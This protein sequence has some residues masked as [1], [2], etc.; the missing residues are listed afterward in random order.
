MID[1]IIDHTND[2]FVKFLNESKSALFT[3]ITNNSCPDS[4][5]T[6]PFVNDN[7]IVYVF[8]LCDSNKIYQI[9]QNSHVSL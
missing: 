9:T 6:G 3:T 4:R 8:T 1:K 2:C 5:I 7:L